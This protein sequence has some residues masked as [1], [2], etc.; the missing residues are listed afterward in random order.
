MRG[1]V[2]TWVNSQWKYYAAP[3]QLSVEINIPGLAPELVKDAYENGVGLKYLNHSIVLNKTLRSP[4]YAAVNLDRSTRLALPKGPSLIRADSRLPVDVQPKPLS[5]RN[6]AASPLAGREDI[7]WGRDLQSTDPSK[8]GEMVDQ[9]V[10]VAVNIVPQSPS[11]NSAWNTLSDWVRAAHN[12]FATRVAIFTGP[13]FSDADPTIDNV[14]VPQ[15]YWKVAV[16]KR[17]DLGQVGGT[18]LV[19]DAFIIRVTSV[20]PTF[21]PALYRMPVVAI[22]KLSGIDF[23]EAVR[24]ADTLNPGLVNKAGLSGNKLSSLLESI[25]DADKDDRL[26]ATQQ[27]VSAIRDD[28]VIAGEQTK[29]LARM[30]EKLSAEEFDKLTLNGRYNLLY[31][32]GQIP[33]TKWQWPEWKDTLPDVTARLRGIKERF[34]DGTLALGPRTLGQLALVRQ[35][36]GDNVTTSSQARPNVTVYLQFAG[37]VRSEAEGIANG[38]KALGWKVPG[39]ERTSEALGANEVRYNADSAEDRAAAIQLIGDFKSLNH[40]MD[41]NP[42]PSKLVQRGILEIWISSSTKG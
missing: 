37:L 15:A 38:L 39:E 40:T 18:P 34:D 17:S 7:S 30:V 31:L 1:T 11:F 42:K 25:D 21:D 13:V 16:S 4:V 41:P 10:N 32:L 19:V 24:N 33:A 5:W 9:S 14:Q 23:G 35:Q 8:A 3:G 26:S 20:A 28:E 6:V 12:P 22:E 29:I 36:L 2:E 27:I